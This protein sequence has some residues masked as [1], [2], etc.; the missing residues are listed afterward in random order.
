MKTKNIKDKL[1]E[2]FFLNT[3]KRLRVRQ[4]ERELKLPLR[5]VIRYT[6][7]LEQEK[8][9]KSE[10]ISNINLYSADRSS[11]FFLLEKKLYNIKLL[12]HLG[13]IDKL[14]EEYNNPVI[15]LFGSFSKGEDIESSDIDLYIE[16][17]RKEKID[18]KQIEKKLNKNIKLFIYK[19]IK[20][21]ENKELANNIINGITLNNFIEVFK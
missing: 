8:I 4:I 21:V 2:Y 10:I 1:K 9:I 7:E 20:E 14:I 12:Y 17:S 3:T 5:S 16:L 11:K 13:L 15:I 19:N 6:K 18:L